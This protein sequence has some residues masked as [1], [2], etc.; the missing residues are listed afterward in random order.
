MDSSRH[1]TPDAIEVARP[2]WK[3]CFWSALFLMAAFPPGVRARTDSASEKS[4]NSDAGAED[5]PG[6]AYIH[7]PGVSTPGGMG[8]RVGFRGRPPPPKDA[9]PDRPTAPAG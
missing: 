1:A 6:R 5:R 8:G 9:P 2:R 7:Q 3:S 4:C